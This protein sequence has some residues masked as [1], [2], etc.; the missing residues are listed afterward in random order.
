MFCCEGW[1]LYAL[2]TVELWIWELVYAVDMAVMAIEMRTDSERE[3]EGA[4]GCDGSECTTSE[5]EAI[6]S[7]VASPRLACQ[8]RN[9]PPI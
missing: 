1:E 7:Q 2:W 3:R 5:F 9:V 6:V 4:N 8:G